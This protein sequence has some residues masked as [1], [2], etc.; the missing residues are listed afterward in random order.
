MQSAALQNPPQPQAGRY[1][2]S[3]NAHATAIR[4]LPWQGKP[5]HT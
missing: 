4:S 1:D 3:L 5:R 2:R